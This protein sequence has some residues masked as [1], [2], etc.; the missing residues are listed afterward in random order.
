MNRID[1]EAQW[2][3]NLAL[4]RKILFMALLSR[5]I[6]IAGR[7]SYS[8]GTD[9]LCNPCL[10]RQINETQHR[11]AGGLCHLLQ[12]TY[13]DGFHVSVASWLFAGT[14]AVLNALLEGCWMQAKMHLEADSSGGDSLTAV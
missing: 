10:L 1:V 9:D 5:Q 8:A 12:R 4:E 13:F 14:D 3:G 11:V 7:T 6:T 2:L